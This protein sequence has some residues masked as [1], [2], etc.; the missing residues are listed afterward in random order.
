M[1]AYGG[2]LVYSHV[3]LT[4]A[5]VGERSASCFGRCDQ[6]GVPGTQ[7]TSYE[8]TRDICSYNLVF[9]VPILVDKECVQRQRKPGSSVERTQLFS[10]TVAVTADETLTLIKARFRV[11]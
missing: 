8:Y 9:F 11:V 3:F 6:G 10:Q 2:V 1:K 5:L 7:W 4:P